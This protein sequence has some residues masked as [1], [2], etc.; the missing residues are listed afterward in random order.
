MFTLTSAAARQILQVTQAGETQDMALRVAARRE[1]DG[2][3]QYGMGFDDPREGD[4]KLELDGVAVVIA[5]PS[6]ALLNDTVLDYVELEPGAF[7]FI[8]IEGS[9]LE[10][11]GPPKQSACG[12]G[13]GAGCAGGGCGAK[14]TMH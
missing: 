8:F 7:N 11:S 5:D 10:D 4:L 13:A 14:G 12:S 9:Q 3:L 2:S 6:Q 1:S